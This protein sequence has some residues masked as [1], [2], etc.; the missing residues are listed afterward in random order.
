MEPTDWTLNANHNL[1][2]YEI[3]IKITSDC[4]E[5]HDIATVIVT[6]A[7]NDSKDAAL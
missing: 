3:E 6:Y 5:K 2:V 1:S 7:L 4:A